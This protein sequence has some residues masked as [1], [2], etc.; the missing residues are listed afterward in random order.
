MYGKNC[1]M[2]RE[3]NYAQN[4]MTKNLGRNY[5]FFFNR[6]ILGRNLRRKVASPI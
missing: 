3:K 6:E 2:K 4:G 5:V 1:W